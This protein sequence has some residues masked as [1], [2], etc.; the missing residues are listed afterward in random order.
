[1]PAPC[2]LLNI[3]QVIYTAVGYLPGL[4]APVAGKQKRTIYPLRYSI[5]TGNGKVACGRGIRVRAIGKKAHGNSCSAYTIVTHIVLAR[6]QV[7]SPGNFY[8]QIIY[9]NRVAIKFGFKCF[10]G[11]GSVVPAIV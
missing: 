9:C 1:M 11:I 5:E 7:V 2:L 6:W 8:M 4:V 3:P 10:G